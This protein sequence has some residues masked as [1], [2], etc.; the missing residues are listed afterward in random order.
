[1]R[2]ENRVGKGYTG[3]PGIPLPE[4]MFQRSR[5]AS[6]NCTNFTEMKTCLELEKWFRSNILL[7]GILAYSC[8]QLFLLRKQAF[9]HFFN[10]SCMANPATAQESTYMD[11]HMDIVKF[12]I[13]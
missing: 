8:D 3:I 11:S 13:Q 6:P 10:A 5:S 2:D 9:I 1:M 7:H 4:P 12:V